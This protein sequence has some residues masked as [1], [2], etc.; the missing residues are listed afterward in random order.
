MMSDD[1][2]SKLHQYFGFDRF[3]KGQREVIERAAKKESAAAIFPTGGG[4]SL[5]YQLPAMMLEHMTLVVSPLLSLMKDQLD[6]L[7]AKNIPAAK[8]DSTLT[9]A[10]YNDIIE[11]AKKGEIKILMISVERFKNE[12]FRTHLRDMKISLIAVDEAHCISEWGHNFRPEYLKLPFYRR[13]FRI[14]QSLLLTATAAPPV[15]DDMCEKFDIPRHHVLVTGFYRSNLYLQVT[16]CA[17]N[18]KN[19]HLLKRLSTHP[20][21]STIVYVTR[22]KTA[23]EIA[24]MLKTNGFAAAAYHAGMKSEE[25]EA[26]Q[27][28]FMNDKVPVVVAT[29]AFGMGIDKVDIRRVIHYNLPKS[30]ESYSQEIGRAGRDNKESLCEVLAD[31]DNINVLE[32]FVYGDTPEASGIENLLM[33]VKNNPGHVWE[34]QAVSMSNQTNIRLLP[35]KTLLVYLELYGIIKSKY[36][37]FEDYS[38]KLLHD[39]DTIINRFDGERKQ[40]VQAMF[41]H[42]ETKRVWTVIDIKGLL[43]GYKVDRSRVIKALEY[44]DRND[45][46]ELRSGQAIDVYDILKKDIDIGGLTGQLV[47][48]FNRKEKREIQRIHTMLRFF[49]NET[50]LSGNLSDYYGE[51][52]IHSCGHCSVCKTGKTE[53]PPPSP[54]PPLATY[55]KEELTS[56]LYDA[57]EQD[58]SAA[59]LTKF[60]CGI[61][62][63]MFS[64][65]KIK[66]LPGFGKLE[67]YPYKTVEE[68]V[69]KPPPVST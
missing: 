56:G 68:W 49:E 22:Q 51:Q 48:L 60:L 41:A 50:C 14:P 55:N 52:G 54:L 18:L 63:P 23:E 45:W 46:L 37:Y 36:T 9:R 31:R 16:P 10:Q 61:R 27:D 12:R 35:L 19:Q 38:F 47:E 24:E 67:D 7:A 58:V 53:I 64:K 57:L 39:R 26:V 43:A 65:P 17:V 4:K 44:F 62:I 34:M 11:K 30:L 2:V 69:K 20:E 40:L 32:N 25:R 5:C 8:L 59:A 29:I 3:L 15:V 1:L 6:F 66:Q 21:D 33:Q 42:S 13:E 28:D